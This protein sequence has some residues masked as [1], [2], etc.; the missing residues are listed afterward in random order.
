MKG[1]DDIHVEKKLPP[2][3]HYFIYMLIFLKITLIVYIHHSKER[4]N[5]QI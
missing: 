3:L 5:E 2:L 4:E 1:S